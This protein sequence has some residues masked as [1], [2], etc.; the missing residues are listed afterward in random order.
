LR[1]LLDPYIEGK[2][3]LKM[4]KR[5]LRFTGFK[6]VEFGGAYLLI[7]LSHKF[8]APIVMADIV[9][10][11]TIVSFFLSGI[12]SLLLLAGFLMILGIVG[13]SLWQLIKKNWEWAGKR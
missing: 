8:L 2:E 9:A 13:V 1:N 4:F 6:I 11:G 5:V 10:K 12:M 7:F 3:R